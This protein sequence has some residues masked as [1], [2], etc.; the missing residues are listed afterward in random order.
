MVALASDDDDDGLL[1]LAVWCVS[2]LSNRPQI[3]FFLLSSACLSRVGLPIPFGT[4]DAS[5]DARGGASTERRAPSCKA[6][7]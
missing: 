6:I 5:R 7:F 1:C 2:V 4:F 3:I